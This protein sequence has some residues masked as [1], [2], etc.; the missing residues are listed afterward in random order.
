MV[1]QLAVPSLAQGPAASPQPVA[2]PF[3]TGMPPEGPKSALIS[4]TIP[5]GMISLQLGV[6][7]GQFGM[8]MVQS[9]LVDNEGNNIAITVKAGQAGVAFGIQ[10]AGTQ[11][12][13]VF[14]SGTNLY[15]TVTLPA[16]QI[17]ATVIAF[18]IFNAF[19]PPASWVSNLS[20]AGNVNI[21]QITG[22]VNVAV[23]G[24]TPVDI[25]SGTVHIAGGA[26]DVTGSMITIEGGIELS[27]AATGGASGFFGV[28]SNALALL[29]GG[30]APTF[31]TFKGGF[32][33]NASAAISYLQVFDAKQTADVTLGAT[34]PNFVFPLQASVNNAI[35]VPPE[36]LACLNGIVVA[37]TTTATGAAAPANPSTGTL[38]YA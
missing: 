19:V 21:A 29:K 20:V 24:T 31:A 27:A 16:A 23:Q 28:F 9:L 18:Q 12:I 1:N 32:L 6:E 30:G 17:T 14:Q 33:N 22:T 7:V 10:P 13:P 37:V 34:T 5:P 3:N 2:F 26:V 15:I 38:Y 36:G 11:I 8:S 35:E 4:L 25:V